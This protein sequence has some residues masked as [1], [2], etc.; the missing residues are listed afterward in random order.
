MLGRSRLPVLAELSGAPKGARARSLRRDDLA[1]L[2]RVLA[3]LGDHR[4][5][6]VGGDG[7]AALPASVALAAAAAAGG[8]RTVLVEC[9]LARPRLAE[10]VGVAAA[11]GLH[12]YL[13]W[14][15]EPADL[16]RPVVLAGPE[17]G[18]AAG[19]LVCVC[20]GRPAGDAEALLGLGSY[21]H[22]VGKLRSAYELT[23][24]IAPSPVSEPGPCLAAAREADAALAA[25]PAS[26]TRGSAGR[27]MR[28]A[29]RRLPPPALGAVVVASA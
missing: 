3:R 27:E 4:V 24:L 29:L 14:E 25:L 15:A 18:K 21:A 16:L 19:P 2:E 12:E 17:A 1:A 13:R 23:V 10:E 22:M 6:L 28:R 7:G 20:A 9:D 5:V 8:R 26:V 11:P